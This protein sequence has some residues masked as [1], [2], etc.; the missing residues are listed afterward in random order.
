LIGCSDYDIYEKRFADKYVNDDKIVLAGGKIDHQ[1]QHKIENETIWVHVVKIPI[2]D[3]EDNIIGSE[4][5]FWN[6]NEE[7]KAQERYKDLFKYSPYGIIV[8]EN[9]IVSD[10]NDACLELFGVKSSDDLKNKYIIDLICEP[11]KELAKT[12]LDQMLKDNSIILP[13]D[14]MC[15]EHQNSNNNSKTMVKVYA[16]PSLTQDK[17][18]QVIYHKISIERS[19][20]FICYCRG[21]EVKSNKSNLDEKYV[22]EMRSY[23]GNFL[24][25]KGLDI[26]IDKEIKTGKDWEDEI[27]KA[28]SVTTIAILMISMDF[29]KSDYV[30]NKE[31]RKIEERR[32]TQNLHIIPIYVRP[33][34]KAILSTTPPYIEGGLLKFQAL[35]N[36]FAK[37]LSEQKN[38][39]EREKLW[40]T[41]YQEI[42]DN[43]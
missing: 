41:L 11:Y 42:I 37:P 33:V 30:I 16:K 26:F 1:E 18:I 35:G 39:V 40:Y 15:L 14:I 5:I 6:V 13:P 25:E 10:A 23:L 36:T 43:I 20:V 22:N 21:K 38:Q 7:K 24:G 32:K 19:K 31:L 34:P 27:Q 28:L 3:L 2:R 9:G 12:R 8:H 4:T 29:V 17:E